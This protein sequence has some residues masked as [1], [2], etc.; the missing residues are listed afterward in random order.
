MQMIIEALI[1]AAPFIVGIML[2]NRDTKK[3]RSN[4]ID[5]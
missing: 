4:S 5:N 1:I 2:I 3:G